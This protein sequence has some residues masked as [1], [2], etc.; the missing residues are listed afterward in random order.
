M[1]TITTPFFVMKNK[2]QNYAW[3]SS[4]SIEQ[5]FD[6]ANPNKHPQAEIW[7]G[8]HPNGCSEVELNGSSLL[9][10]ELIAQD[11]SRFLSQ[12]TAAQF[13][14]LPYLFKVLAAAQALSVQVHPSK[15]EAQAGYAKENAAGIEIKAANRNYKDPNHKPELVYAITPYQAMNG[16]RS[17][18][19]IIDHFE[20]LNIECIQPLV[21]ELRN[22]QHEQGLQQF[23]TL[24]LS[25][26]GDAKRQAVAKLLAYAQSHQSQSIYTLI[27]ELAEQYP[28]DI[29]LF[30]PLMLNVLTLQPGEA[31]Y[32]DARTPHAYL[33]GTGLEIMA[34]SD[35]VLRAG[36]TPKH[37]DV[38]ELAKCTRFAEKPES[39]LLLTP[40][41][42]DGALLYPV[43]V[44]DFKFALYTKP[45]QTSVTVSS[46]EIIFPIDEDATLI[47]DEGI[48]VTIRKGQSVFV[49]AYTAHYQLSSAGRVAR[50]YN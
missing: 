46:A 22:N 12:Q 5:L 9:L 23:F 17:I 4:D 16:F 32:L 50:A 18:S 49:P 35:N 21:E 26:T 45:S 47:S 36:L 28:N 31:M 13:G 44:D 37:M 39:T 19:S 30:A 33:K 41:E 43:P 38:L 10:S 27:L 40:I 6:I 42:Q 15:E 48:E 2:I 7:M 25:L 34:N 20:P 3:G 29:G 11:K 14:E 24:L 8:A 1:N